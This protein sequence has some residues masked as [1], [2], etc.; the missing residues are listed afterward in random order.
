M[1]YLNVSQLLVCDSKKTFVLSFVRRPLAV[2]RP[3]GHPFPTPPSRAHSFVM[4]YNFES[5]SSIVANTASPENMF[6][7][8]KIKI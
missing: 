7:I 5:T 1:N 3:I 2:P 4:Y 8:F 6:T